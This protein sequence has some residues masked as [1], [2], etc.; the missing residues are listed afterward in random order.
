MRQ[1]RYR[2]PPLHSVMTFEAVARLHSMTNA[3]RELRVTREAVS[4]QIRMLEQFVGVKLFERTSRV[5]SLTPSGAEFAATVAPALE[6]IAGATDALKSS[7]VTT[8]LTVTA[9]VAIS[10]YWLTP[11]LASF[12]QQHPRVSLRVLASDRHHDQPELDADIGL[13][14]GDGTWPTVD[15]V[16]LCD[17]ESFPVCSADYLRSYP[18]ITCA[19][20]LLGHT[21]IHLEGTQHSTEDWGWWLSRAG[22]TIDRKQRHIVFSSYVDVIQAAISGQGIALGYTPA[23]SFL[24]D[25]NTLVKPLELSFTKGLSMYQVVGRKSVHTRQ[26]AQFSSWLAAQLDASG[27]GAAYALPGGT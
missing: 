16:K 7:K 1:L 8:Q 17:S 27:N 19:E 25:N 22:L 14:Y 10:S 21:L 13:W 15:A 23:I 11:R 26:I 9:S 3:A 18:P 5:I 2:L 24:V 6:S 12:Y 20:D 4:R